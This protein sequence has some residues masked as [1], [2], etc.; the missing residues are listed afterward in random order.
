MEDYRLLWPHFS[1]SYLPQVA[2]L[3]GPSLET[4]PSGY[5]T[6]AARARR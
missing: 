6:G 3:S 5:H 1:V 2:N 4:Y